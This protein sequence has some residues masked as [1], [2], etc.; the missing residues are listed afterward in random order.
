MSDQTKKPAITTTL[1]EDEIVEQ[2]PARRSVLALL[3]ATVLGG[4]AKA[5][6]GCMVS[7]PQPIQTGP[8]QGYVVQGQP[9]TVVVQGGQQ[10]GLTDSDSGSYADPVNNGRGG[11]RGV[12]TGLTDGDSGTYSDPVNGGRG[13][14][15]RG[16]AT[17]L[18]DGD[19]G[20]GS[21]PVGNGRGTARLGQTGIT[22]SDTGQWADGVGHGR[23]RRW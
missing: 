17:G 4:A 6:G 3:S 11:P 9:Q 22:D 14:Y 8:Q 20:A 23:G 16:G 13:H 5:L 15:G 10:S 1:S 2:T 18:T 12:Q 7:N 19:A 21:D